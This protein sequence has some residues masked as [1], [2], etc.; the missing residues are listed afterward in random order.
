MSAPIGDPGPVRQRYSFSSLLSMAPPCVHMP[1]LCQNHTTSDVVPY[2]DPKSREIG[3]VMS[4]VEPL[5]PDRLRWRCDPEQLGFE[6]TAE[7][8]PAESFIGQERGL[9]A[10]E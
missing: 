3:S 1:P 8:A 5:P 7:V 10:I 6:T 4:G 2:C 9:E